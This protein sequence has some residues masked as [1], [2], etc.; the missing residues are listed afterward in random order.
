M[1]D[2][3][4]STEVDRLIEIL[5]RDKSADLDYLSRELNLTPAQLRKWISVLEE[6]HFVKVEYKLTKVNVIWSGKQIG[7]AHV[8]APVKVLPT[9]PEIKSESIPL[10]LK[11]PEPEAPKPESELLVSDESEITGIKE[12]Q[13]TA[14]ILEEIDRHSRMQAEKSKM[15]AHIPEEPAQIP[16]AETGKYIPAEPVHAPK[17]SEKTIKKKK[18]GNGDISIV[19]PAPSLLANTKISPQPSLPTSTEMLT[20]S[21]RMNVQFVPPS[22]E[23]GKTE[24]PKTI[25]PLEQKTYPELEGLPK[26]LSHRLSEVRKQAD[27]IA[28]LRGEKERLLREVYMPLQAKMEAD[29]GTIAERLLDKEKQIL[30]LQ[31]RAAE[32]PA[33]TQEMEKKYLKLQELEHE[34]RDAYDETVN[35]IDQEGT[36][37]RSMHEQVSEEMDSLRADMLEE[38]SKISGMEQER[39]RLTALEKE[40]KQAIGEARKRILLQTESI[41]LLDDTAKTI[42][43][44]RRR[45]GRQIEESQANLT[46]QSESLDTL[47][48]K[49]STLSKAE[50]H[51]DSHFEQYKRSM[52][53]FNEYVDNASAEYNKLR[54]SVEANFAR[55]YLGKLRGVADKYQFELDSVQEKEKELDM[56]IEAAR[57]RM[58]SLIR[59][60]MKIVHEHEVQK[61][62]EEFSPEELISRR[63]RMFASLEELAHER[64]SVQETLSSASRE[65]KRSPKSPDSKKGKKK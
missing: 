38:T 34:A 43:S 28:R 8:S 16:K 32:I 21:P 9:L 50:T 5:Q 7:E 61:S 26:E 37:L 11:L 60:G 48:E 59:D 2:F 4:I 6:Q 30:Q 23:Q 64:K 22:T 1:E 49:L 40:A 41:E 56:S 47:Q 57:G 31:G 29:I 19:F 33:K 58:S 51:L 46:S 10:H 39:Q 54:E 42:A 17:T 18:S 15:E 35:F 3:V 53:E 12:E 55:L 52:G 20:S 13:E 45:A 14:E 62:D 65:L 25:L 27:E 36:R 24:Q 63:E 44:L